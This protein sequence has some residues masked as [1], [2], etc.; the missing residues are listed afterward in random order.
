MNSVFFLVRTQN[1]ALKLADVGQLATLS[2]QI[3]LSK[4]VLTLKLVTI[5]HYLCTL[6]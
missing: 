4:A 3:A 2:I 1:V 6:K 5:K